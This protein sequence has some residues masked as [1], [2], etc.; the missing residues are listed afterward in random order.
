MEVDLDDARSRVRE[1]QIY[2]RWDKEKVDNKY[3]SAF[4]ENVMRLQSVSRS[5]SFLEYSVR[6]NGES[7]VI[8]PGNALVS[9]K[10]EPKKFMTFVSTSASEIMK[11]WVV[12]LLAKPKEL[13]DAVYAF[14]QEDG[15]ELRL[16][17]MSTFPALFHQFATREFQKLGLAFLQRL[18]RNYDRLF[19]EPFLVSF[20]DCSRLFSCA[21][22]TCFED[23]GQGSLG[24]L[25]LGEVFVFVI[26]ALKVAVNR[27]SV[28][29]QEAISLYISKDKDDFNSFI[30]DF[31]LSTM[32]L[33]LPHLDSVAVQRREMAVRILEYVSKTP[34]CP[35]ASYLRKMFT[36][37][38]HRAWVPEHS[39]SQFENNTPI[40]LSVHEFFFIQGI[41]RSNPN[42]VTLKFMPSFALRES[43]RSS[44]EPVFITI[45][46]PSVFELETPE[47]MSL[48]LRDPLFRDVPF[49]NRENE[50]SKLVWFELKHLG[51]DPIELLLDKSSQPM[52]SVQEK[53]TVNYTTKIEKYIAMRTHHKLLK[54]ANSFE[55]F[56]SQ[57]TND[58]YYSDCIFKRRFV[59][60]RIE[61][62]LAKNLTGIGL[63]PL[64]SLSTQDRVPMRSMAVEMKRDLF[65][66]QSSILQEPDVDARVQRKISN[67]QMNLMDIIRRGDHKSEMFRRQSIA[68]RIKLPQREEDHAI[69]PR[70]PSVKKRRK[71]TSA[72]QKELSDI[73][74]KNS[75]RAVL[76]NGPGYLELKFWIFLVK[77]DQCELEDKKLVDLSKKVSEHMGC[78]RFEVIRRK[79][80]WKDKQ[81]LIVL[82]KKL[83][84]LREL[85]KGSA[86]VALLEFGDALRTLCLETP[87]HSSKKEEVYGNIFERCLVLANNDSFYDCF[88]WYE[89]MLGSFPELGTMFSAQDMVAIEF[90]Q[91]MF[92]VFLNKLSPELCAKTKECRRYLFQM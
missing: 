86:V 7:K 48:C 10:L 82:A 33:F 75:L 5:I 72:G 65:S 27:L 56:I 28:Y 24:T 25:T 50:N 70:P 60:Q 69:I 2:S 90:L 42:L 22:W 43:L 61:Y 71:S 1:L 21:F 15:S 74:F 78:L 87:C 12:E 13:A 9:V 37:A 30:C 91:R 83:N 59:F 32:A 57:M 68:E 34:K 40:V 19:F 18:I 41:V 17:S 55:S 20:I 62:L 11:Q 36:G 35:Q 39:M 88:V 63:I 14:F 38:R 77:M 45:A 54:L 67:T 79:E 6:D 51:V 46:A 58:Q 4:F 64:P 92:W 23:F 44:F 31:L 26:K 16:F 53:L 84:Y 29:Q 66:S 76:N 85:K 73:I 52:R 89:K 8:S 80:Q 47:R 3:T 81:R 49:D